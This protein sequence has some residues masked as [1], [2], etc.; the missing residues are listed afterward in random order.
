MNRFLK[1]S[2]WFA[3]G[4]NLIWTSG[5]A[6]PQVHSYFYN[7]SP[8][9]GCDTNTTVKPP[10][11]NFQQCRMRG[12]CVWDNQGNVPG[13]IY[14]VTSRAEAGPNCSTSAYLAE[15]STGTTGYID[16]NSAST[17]FTEV[18]SDAYCQCTDGEIQGGCIT[19]GGSTIPC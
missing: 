8:A 12:S 17:R 5:I 3:A 10:L 2:C 6:K 9:G 19:T 16:A 7:W 15:K 1:Y 14:T 4:F 18:D 13:P 11:Y